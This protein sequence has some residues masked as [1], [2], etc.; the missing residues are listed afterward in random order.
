[1][2]ARVRVPS[3]TLSKVKVTSIVWHESPFRLPLN[4][5]PT[6][7]ANDSLQIA[8]EKALVNSLKKHMACK[9]TKAVQAQ[10]N[11]LHK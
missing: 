6:E 9:S 8:K 7:S 1:V 4:D 3:V 11:T 5:H 2:S 10:L